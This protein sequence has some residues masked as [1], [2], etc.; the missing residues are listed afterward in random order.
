MKKK[1]VLVIF[2]GYSNEYYVSC[3]SAAGILS[4]IDT[5]LF[6]VVKIGITLEGQ[7]ILTEATAEQICDGKE[8]LAHDTNRPAIISPERDKNS[9]LIFDGD[10][11]R[12]QSIDCVFPLIHGF[13]GED[14]KLQGLLELA[15]IPYVGSGVASSANSMDKA[16]TGIFSD[17]CN[18]KRPVCEVVCKDEFEQ[19]TEACIS[20]EYPVFVKPA[21][22]GSSVGVSKVTSDAELMPAL[23]DAFLYD[24]KVIVEQGIIG[25]EIKVALLEDVENKEILIGA[26]CDLT[27]PDGGVNDYDTKYVKHTSRKQIPAEMDESLALLIKEQAVEIFKALECKGFARADFFLTADGEIYFNEINTIPGIGEESIYSLMMNAVGISYTELITKLVY[28]AF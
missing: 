15:N 18:L 11:I 12:H 8:W 3:S 1:S 2:G 23:Q 24:N 6:E 16:I 28:T 27:V 22:A 14:G 5:D 7:W 20:M 17:A 4:H 19:E 10:A 25:R 9:I 13:G 21:N 26:L